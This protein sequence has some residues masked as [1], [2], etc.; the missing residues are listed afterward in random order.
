[1]GCAVTADSNNVY[2]FGGKNDT[3]RLNDLW[4]FS[5]TDFKY[6]RLPNEG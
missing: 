3:E 6:K 5:L 4:A 2:V 1:M